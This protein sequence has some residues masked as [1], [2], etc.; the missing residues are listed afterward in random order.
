MQFLIALRRKELVFVGS[1]VRDDTAI[2]R[3]FEHNNFGALY[4]LSEGTGF[5]ARVIKSPARMA[6]RLTKKR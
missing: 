6:G 2:F 5:T 3:S 4:P 1:H